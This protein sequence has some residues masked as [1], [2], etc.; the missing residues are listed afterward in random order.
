MFE[1]IG[2][3]SFLAYQAHRFTK[4]V[5]HKDLSE[6]EDSFKNKGTVIHSSKIPPAPKIISSHTL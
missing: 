6:E 3:R 1:K 5:I 4:Y 2:N